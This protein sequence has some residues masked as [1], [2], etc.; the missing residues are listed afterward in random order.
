VRLDTD[1]EYAARAGS[2]WQHFRA[3]R[4]NRHGVIASARVVHR[5]A[6]AGRDAGR[7]TV[8]ALLGCVVAGLIGWAALTLAVVTIVGVFVG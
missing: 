7:M 8:R 4:V 1:E 2:A 3:C 5:T 6:T